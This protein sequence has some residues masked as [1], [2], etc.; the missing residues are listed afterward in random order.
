METIAYSE[1]CFEV[2]R[3]VYYML[4]K[5]FPT[6][7]IFEFTKE[8]EINE[9]VAYMRYEFFQR[10]SDGFIPIQKVETEKETY[11]EYILGSMLPFFKKKEG[12]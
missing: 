8:F 11:A 2:K 10:Y 9:H 5:T 12:V 3:R 7:T 6:L 4:E 1:F